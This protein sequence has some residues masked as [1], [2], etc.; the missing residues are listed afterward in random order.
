[1]SIDV[2]ERDVPDAS[3]C[4]PTMWT[5]QAFLNKGMKNITGKKNIGIGKECQCKR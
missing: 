3:N 2:R 4:L 1:M 5:E